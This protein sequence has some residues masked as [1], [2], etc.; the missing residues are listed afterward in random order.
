M[1]PSQR[2]WDVVQT[3][4]H[5]ARPYALDYIT[6]L[7]PNFVELHGDRV[8]HDDPALVGGL[9]TWRERTV[10]FIGQQKGRHLADR[11]RRNWGMLHPEGYRKALR[12]AR[13]AAKFGF[14]IV[15]LVDT[16]GAYPGLEAEE[17]GIASAIGT[18][19]M[20]WFE[21]VVPIVAVVIG[22]GGSGGALG[23]AVADSV[24][25]LE[26]SIYSV[27]APEAA[28]SIVWRDSSRRAEI[29]ELLGL[30]A[31]RAM[32]LG[33]IDGIV[34]EPTGG[35]H[36]DHDA[37]AVE[38]DAALWEHLRPLLAMPRTELLGRRRERFRRI[39]ADASF[40]HRPPRRRFT[41]ECETSQESGRGPVPE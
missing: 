20:Q 41:D 15:S 21:V 32:E 25:M 13:Q 26:N 9:G 33:I 16:P 11:V 8:S 30:T 37:A 19:I 4:R 17:R 40:A 27:A 31:P 34:E 14:P 6:R 35:A 1:A 24:L 2:A 23:V 28:A 3:A 7:V 10:L 12:L 39:D 5:V 29:A 38:L 22:E 36:T 18:A